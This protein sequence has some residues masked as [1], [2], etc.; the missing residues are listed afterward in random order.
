[1]VIHGQAGGKGLHGTCIDP[2]N[3]HRMAM[4]FAIAGLVVP[5]MQIDNESCVAKSFPNFWKRLEGMY[6]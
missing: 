6:G 5:G 1:M 3:D 2:H 4:C